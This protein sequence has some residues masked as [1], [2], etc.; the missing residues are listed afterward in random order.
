MDTDSYGINIAFSNKQTPLQTGLLKAA[1]N[2]LC[3]KLSPVIYDFAAVGVRYVGRGSSYL[4]SWY[5]KEVIRGQESCS[6]GSRW[7]NRNCGSAPQV[8]R[9]MSQVCQRDKS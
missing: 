2:V 7:Q 4:P 8:K 5:L 9:D 3:N 6:G 1:L